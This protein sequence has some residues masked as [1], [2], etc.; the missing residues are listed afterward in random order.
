MNRSSFILLISIGCISQV[1][2]SQSISTEVPP[3][4]GTVTFKIK[5]SITDPSIKTK[6][7]A[8]VVLYDSTISQG[9]LL[10]FMPG[11]TGIP[12][13]GP[14]DFFHTA[15]AQGY[16]V[17]NLSYR[18]MLAVARACKGDTLAND[19]LCTEKF[20]TKRIYGDNLISL[21]ADEP[22][23][24]IVNR[25]TKLLI[26]LTGF[27]KQGNWGH[28]LENDTLRWDR[29]TLT[30][31]SQGGGMAA[32]IAK[33]RLVDRVITFSGGWDYSAKSTIA[34]WYYKESVT[35][36]ERW[37]GAYNTAEP[38]ASVL[39]ET[40]QAMNIPDNHVYALNKEVRK[41]RKGHVEGV[42]NPAYQDTWIEMLGKG[43]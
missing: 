27:D 23:D 16:R 39:E 11:T 20:R 9:K 15:L 18:N 25:L 8:H 34:K 10:V 17:I 30:G 21:N 29:L 24:A 33:D 31:Q 6:D 7:D 4:S 41:G 43:N 13:R 5:P 28:Y 38:M 3:P 32:F 1:A 36:T 22:Q 26:Y 42:K 40:Y 12:E 19:P 14:F 37:Y 2:I 35:P